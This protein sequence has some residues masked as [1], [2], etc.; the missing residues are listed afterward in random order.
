MSVQVNKEIRLIPVT[1]SS[2]QKLF[3]LMS[4]IYPPVYNHLWPDGGTYYINKLYCIENL[5]SELL[6]PDSRYYFVDY[7]TETIG[8]LKVNLNSP[9]P[10][11]EEKPMVK[12]HRIYLSPDVQGKGI[13]K[14]LLNW[15]EDTFCKESSIPLWLEVMDTQEQA[16]NFYENFGFVRV[17]SSIFEDQMMKAPFRG[18][19]TMVKEF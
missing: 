1:L 9:L 13:G 3:Q 11:G 12:L 10:G 8:I 4:V 17:G 18:M 16:I 6:N 5:K 2:Q 19:Y 14:L 7:S 15:V